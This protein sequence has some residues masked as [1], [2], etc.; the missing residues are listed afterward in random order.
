MIRFTAL[1]ALT[2]LTF[3]A[4]PAHAYG[5]SWLCEN[6]MDMDHD[7]ARAIAPQNGLFNILMMHREAWD[8]QHMR[9]QCEAFAAGEPYEISCLNDRRDW[10]AIK[11]M[12]PSEFFGRS[13]LE[14]TPHFHAMPGNAEAYIEVARY[15]R[16]VGAIE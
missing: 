13:N 6:Q 14:L 12:V 16:G 15:C 10:D 11:A 2:A 1:A 9:E 4:P 8:L 7:E 5:G 3:T